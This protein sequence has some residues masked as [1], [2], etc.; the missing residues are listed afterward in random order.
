M[1]AYTTC[2]DSDRAGIWFGVVLRYVEAVLGNLECTCGVSVNGV[3]MVKY[4][5][6][7]YLVRLLAD[8]LRWCDL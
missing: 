8:N 4:L 5:H 6:T 7:C 3:G 2:E 1:L